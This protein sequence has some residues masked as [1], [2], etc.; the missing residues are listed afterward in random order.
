MKLLTPYVLVC[1]A[2]PLSAAVWAQPAGYGLVGPLELPSLRAA[3]DWRLETLIDIDERQQLRLAA[4]PAL[5]KLAA[6]GLANDP[7]R[8]T[9]RYTVLS[10]D[11]WAW[12]VG[13]SAHPNRIGGL[14]PRADSAARFGALPLLHMAGEARIAQRWQ[15]GLDADGLMTARGRALELG[16]SVRY[17]RAPTLS[18]YGGWRLS[19]AGG[20]AEEF[21]GSGSAHAANVG[22]RLRF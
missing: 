7:A 13:L 5:H 11:N 20:E 22:L 17:R 14:A 12:R 3:R 2:A 21:Y 8:A 6:A 4:R 1:L 10:Q 9:Y 18:V 15:L 19:D 16:L